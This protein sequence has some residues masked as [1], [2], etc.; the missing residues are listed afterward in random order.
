MLGDGLEP[1]CIFPT[2]WEAIKSRVNQVGVPLDALPS[3]HA[4]ASVG[5]L[6][7][8]PNYVSAQSMPEGPNVIIFKNFKMLERKDWKT[9]GRP[10]SPIRSTF[11]FVGR[12]LSSDL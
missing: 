5:L 6:K 11:P 2:H 1:D 8:N 4:S 9:G 12:D 10:S 7:L 3:T